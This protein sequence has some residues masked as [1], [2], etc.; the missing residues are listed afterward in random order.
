MAATLLLMACEEMTDTQGLSDDGKPTVARL[1]GSWQIEGDD[2]QA[3]ETGVRLT[4][5][6]DGSMVS[7]QNIGGSAI[8]AS[9][10]WSLRG[11]VLTM[12]VS[13][14]G[15]TS[16][17]VGKVTELTASRFCWLAGTDD[18]T[19]ICYLRYRR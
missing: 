10:T 12:R 3:D 11:D 5:N 8:S 15:I 18:D 14:L 17:T 7:S 6:R 9:G 1:I 4:F 16:E 2:G 13:A 19:E